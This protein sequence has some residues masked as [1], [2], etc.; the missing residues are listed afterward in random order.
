MKFATLLALTAGVSS[1][2]VIEID[3]FNVNN[4]MKLDLM[5]NL[6]KSTAMTAVTLAENGEFVMDSTKVSWAQCDD[7]KNVFTLDDD[8]TSATPDPLVKG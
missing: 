1:K 5:P 7:D 3:P 2:E 8:N 4:F 6:L